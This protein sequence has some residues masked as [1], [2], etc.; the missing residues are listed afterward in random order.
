MGTVLYKGGELGMK[1]TAINGVGLRGQ[2]PK[3]G[4]ANEVAPEDSLHTL[5]AVHTDA[6]VTGHGSVFSDE[7][8]VRAALLVLQPLLLGETP[9][10]PERVSEKL[11]QH[12]FWLGMGGT[13]THTQSGIDIALWDILG[14]VTGQPVGRLLGGRYRDR[15]KAYCSVLMEEPAKMREVLA[16]Y[17][18]NGFRAFKIGWGP[19]GRKNSRFDEAIVKIAR[20]TIGSECELMVDAG[21]SDAFWPHGYKWALRT[22]T[23]L[24]EYDVSWFEEPLSPDAVADYALLRRGSPIAIAGGEVLTRRQTFRTWMEQRAVD[25]VQPDVTKVGGLS[26]QRRIAHMAED[27]GI[28]YVGHGWNTALGLACDLQLASALPQVRFVEYIGGS[29]YVDRIANPKF[30]LDEDGCL[31]IPSS[32]GLGVSLDRA[33]LR[34]YTSDPQPLFE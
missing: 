10:E 32:P 11:A 7:R 15:V 28:Q 20:D 19:F 2:T 9:L 25:I 34:A 29:A 33:M 27:F 31:Q 14:K 4:W 16:E 24:H 23:M 17:K 30:V 12:S 21:A 6:G 18:A 8:L 26:E 3:G 13:L 5:I 22:A 1:I